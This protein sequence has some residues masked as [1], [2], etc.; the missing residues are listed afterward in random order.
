LPQVG[1]VVA[2]AVVSTL[3]VSNVG[4]MIAAMAM[5]TGSVE[6][7]RRGSF[8]SANASVQHIAAGIGASLG[9]LIITELPV[10]EGHKYH[11]LEHYGVVGWIAAVVTLSSLWFAGRVRAASDVDTDEPISETASLAAA[12]EVTFDV[13]EPMVGA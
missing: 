13:G 7:S 4:R 10:P 3:M 11:P 9:G 5:I 6:R 1:I 12:A 2:V 8:M